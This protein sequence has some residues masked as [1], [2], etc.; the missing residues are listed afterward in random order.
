MSR[1]RNIVIGARKNLYEFLYNGIYIE[2]ACAGGLC[3]APENIYRLVRGR[4]GKVTMK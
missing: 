1:G 2:P 4:R 3:N